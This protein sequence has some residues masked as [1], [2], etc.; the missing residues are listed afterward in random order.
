MGDV[1]AKEKERRAAQNA[2]DKYVKAWEAGKEVERTML[3]RFVCQNHFLVAN[4][5]LNQAV[6]GARGICCF[7]KDDSR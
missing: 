6:E 7:S 4:L 2:M 3:V 1:E 5:F